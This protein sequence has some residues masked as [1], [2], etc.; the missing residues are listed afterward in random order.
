M[1]AVAGLVAKVYFD[2]KN[3]VDKV[4]EEL[5][6]SELREVNVNVEEQEPISILLLGVDEREGDSGRSDTMI[7]VTVNPETKDSKMLSIPRDT[8]TEIEGHGMDKINHAFAYGGIELSRKT[9]ENLLE[10]PI[11]YV[12]QVNMESF[13]DIIDAV[14]G[15]TI[16]NTL[17]FEYGGSNFPEGTITLDGDS[18]LNYVRMRYED[19]EGDFGRQNRQKKVIQG[20]ASS[21]VSVD[22]A[23]NYKS[24]FESIE[25]NVRVNASYDELM[26]MQKNY[27][28]SFG[29]I[30]QLYINDG[31]GTKIDGIYYYIPDET[32]LETVKSTLKTHLE[33]NS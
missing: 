1:L 33:L 21:A 27:K 13:K 9:V 30:E 2:A 16:D 11:D 24:I 32:Q 26:T 7:V 18:A 23:L 3:T 14:G 29:N 8:Y 22:T 10:I 4:Y 20:I 6:K 15:I 31:N 17:A 19:P 12:V 25:D 5:D 28:N